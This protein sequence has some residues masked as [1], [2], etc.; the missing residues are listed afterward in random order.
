M[1]P[2]PLRITSCMADNAE[3]TCR[4]ITAWLGQRLGIATI[5]DLADAGEMSYSGV[6]T[7]ASEISDAFIGLVQR[8]STVIGVLLC[9]EL[10]AQ[11]VY[12]LGVWPIPGV[13]A[14][15]WLEESVFGA[16]LRRCLA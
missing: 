13:A 6:N 16:F 10:I 4:A 1:Q 7:I 3:A 15:S 8:V 14:K 9:V 5:G 11:L 2:S 12:H